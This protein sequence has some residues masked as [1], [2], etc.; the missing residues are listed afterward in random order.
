LEAFESEYAA[1]CG[2]GHC[3]GV[4]NGT[5]AIELALRAVGAGPGT[6]V[7]TVSHTF[8]ATVEAVQATG[9]R[10]VLVDVEPQTRCM[11]PAA[12]GAA[13]TSR[14][15][16][17]LPVHLYGRPAP[18]EAVSAACASARIPMVEDAAQAHGAL[19]EGRRTG[20]VGTAGCF[21]FYPTKNLGA[22]GDGG[23]VITNDEDVAALVRSLRHHGSSPGD[24]NRHHYVGRTERLDNLQAAILRLKLRALDADNDHR[25][26]AA[27]QYRERLAGLPLDLP[28]EDPPEGRAVHHLFVIE[29]DDRDRVREGLRER[30]VL[31]GVH[32]PTPVH[33]QPG[34]AH[35]GYE[36]GDLPVTERLA[37]RIL[38]LP[39]F[40][41]IEEREIERV[42]D[43]LRACLGLG[44]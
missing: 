5:A 32:Y 24:A 35:L 10:P 7:I 33:M 43:A 27:D 11:D 17:I 41:G 2:S 23:A 4:A 29:L 3:V 16:A 13:V 14:T 42:V 22:M 18:L 31:A 44:S 26:W 8:V 15:R 6:E 40:P 36:S 19:L 9:A 21:S 12:A 37:E 28:P 20:T 39:I 25:R 34:W 1:F 38:S 30:G